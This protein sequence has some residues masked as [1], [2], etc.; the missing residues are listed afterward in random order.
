MRMI[1]ISAPVYEGMAGFPGD[2]PVEVRPVSSIA[3]GDAY[4]LSSLAFGSHTGTHIDPP[5]HFIPGG[6][7]VDRVDLADLNGPCHVLQVPA[8]RTVIGAAELADLPPGIERLLLRTSNSPRWERDSE[9]FPDFVALDV[10]AAEVLASRRL[11]LVGI[12]AQSIESDPSGSYPVHH[13]LLKAG[14]LILEGLRLASVAPGRYELR[15][16]P[17][18]IRDGDGGPA[19]AVLLAL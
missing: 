8:G 17:L 7:T 14:V 18:R 9:F 11:H 3:R 13:R 1:D 15:C 19:R 6:L 5:A 12:D 2:P 16:L 4:N 10:S